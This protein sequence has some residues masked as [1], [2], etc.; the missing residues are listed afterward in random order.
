MAHSFSSAYSPAF[1]MGDEPASGEFGP[2]V[3]WPVYWTCD[4]SA[5]APELTG[6]AVSMATRVLWSM[7]GRQFGTC[8]TTLR[9]CRREC[10]DSWPWGWNQWGGDTNFTSSPYGD[11]RYW[12]PMSCG[13]CSGPCGCGSLSEVVLPS[14]VSEIVSVKLDGV[15]VT[16]IY[17]VDNN[18]FLV[19]TDGG[20]WPSC[21]DLSK[22]DTEIGTWSVTATYGQNVPDAAR[23][24]MGELACEILRAGAGQECKLPAG[25]RSVVRQGVQIEYININDLLEKGKTGLRLVDL[26][27]A[28]ENPDGLKQRGRTYNVDRAL[29]RRAGT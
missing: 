22:N 24:A 26:F 28:A 5:Y 18:R 11:W 27:L 9:P 3:D 2:C 13:Q 8:T 4:I 14:P 10:Y 7:S 19:R 29:H 16:G 6:Y 17:R 21:N 15:A 23:L 25:I 12:F 1:D 20:V